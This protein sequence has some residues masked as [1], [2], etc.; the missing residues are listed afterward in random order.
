MAKEK[1]AEKKKEKEKYDKTDHQWTVDILDNEFRKESDRA[2]VILVASLLDEAL[3]SSLKS[4]LTPIASSSDEIFDGSNAPLGT[5]SSKINMIHRLGLISSRFCRDL[6]LVRKIRNSF[7]HN[8][9][10]CTFENGSVKSRI[11][12]LI[13]SAIGAK[14]D[15]KEAELPDGH[16]GDFIVITA[17]NKSPT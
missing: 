1:S 16:K 12:E 14:I 17:E 8:I 9:F 15:K 7:A 11:D 3:T 10:G 13:K 5:F 6:H 4:Y 2:V